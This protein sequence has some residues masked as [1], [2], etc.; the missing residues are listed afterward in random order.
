MAGGVPTSL[1]ALAEVPTDG[2]DLHRL[3]VAMTGASPLPA[4][5]RERFEKVTGLT[6]KEIYGMTEAS[7]LISC[8]PVRG[9]GGTGSVGLRFPYTSVT[10]RRLGDDGALGEICDPG[11]VGVVTVSGPTVSPGYRDPA[12]EAGTFQDG[13]L[14]TGDLGRLDHEGR[15]VLEGR[16]KDLIIRSG[17]NIDPQMIESALQRHPDVVLAAAVGRPDA[18][19]GELPVCYVELRPGSDVSEEELRHFA[20]QELGER[21]AWPRHVHVVPQIPVTA[22]GKIFK[23]SL[24]QNAVEQVVR[25]LL[26]EG[27]LSGSVTASGGGGGLRGLRVEITLHDASPADRTRLQVLLDGYLMDSTVSL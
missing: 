20:E 18:Y 10:C 6:V 1:G 15:L 16:A 13:V 24:R 4:A 23:P 17:H 25:A 27:G 14:V 26:D 2:A 21:P 22:V 11:E 9:T 8:N 3:R 7:G 5:V 12:Q 19:A